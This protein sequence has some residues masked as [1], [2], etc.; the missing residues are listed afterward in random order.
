L[1]LKSD[2]HGNVHFK[3]VLTG[4]A[5]QIVRE[6]VKQI[7]KDADDLLAVDKAIGGRAAKGLKEMQKSF[8][9]RGSKEDIGGDSR[10]GSKEENKAA[11]SRR[12]SKPDI[13]EGEAAATVM[14][15]TSEAP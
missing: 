1:G 9:R 11:S 13:E 3:D 4:L 15:V 10:R 14:A 6:Q 5:N 12:S 8:S 7:G 2:K